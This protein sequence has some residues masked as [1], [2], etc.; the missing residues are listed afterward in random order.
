MDPFVT[1]LRLFGTE[2]P[3]GSYG[4]LLA[5][6]LVLGS[7]WAVRAA[8]RAG[9]DPGAVVAA[10]G[11]GAAGAFVS[12]YLAFVV[13]EWARTGT[14]VD[15]LRQPGLVFYGGPVGGLAVLFL[16]CRGLSI[17]FGRFADVAVPAAPAAHALG[18]LGCF[19]GG[20]CFGAPFEGAWAVRATHPFAPAAHPAVWRHPV[21][22]YESGALLCIALGLTLAPPRRVGSGHRLVLYGFLYGIVRLCTEWFRGDRVR[23]VWMGGRVSTSQLVS[24]LL[25]AVCLALLGWM[26]RRR[27][28]SAA[29]SAP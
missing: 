17:P 7:L 28:P 26:A 23:G 12:A 19:L 18:R 24:M 8:A 4:L 22:L 5:L 2:R 16:A 9:L 15:A 20:C 13:V 1:V 3:I 6:A 25:V 27:P 21:Q 29:P 14:P 11:F 10:L